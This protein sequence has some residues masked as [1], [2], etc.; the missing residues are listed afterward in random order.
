MS[1]DQETPSIGLIPWDDGQAIPI[2]RK[3]QA[4]ARGQGSNRI[5]RIIQR[6]DREAEVLNSAHRFPYV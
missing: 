3:H 5:F 6:D 4:N 1:F 2:L